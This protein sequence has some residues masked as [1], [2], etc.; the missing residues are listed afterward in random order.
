[1]LL[2]FGCLL[3]A[4]ICAIKVECPATRLILSSCYVSEPITLVDDSKLTIDV[5]DD[6]RSKITTFETAPNSNLTTI[7]NEIFET[8]AQLEVISLPL[9]NIWKLEKDALY[10]AT[11]LQILNLNGNNLTILGQ[12]VFRHA[13]ELFLLNLADNQINHIADGAFDRL[14]K[15]QTLKLNGN[16]LAVLSAGV[17]DGLPN[18][19]YL[20]LHDNQL[21]TIEPNMLAL[22]KLSEV[23]FTRNALSSLPEN[24]FAGTPNVAYVSFDYNSLKRI[25]NLFDG[26]D[27]LVFLSLDCNH[28]SDLS[29]SKFAAL[30]SLKVLSLNGTHIVLPTTTETLTTATKSPLMSL[31]LGN[32][33]L[34]NAD[35]MQH[36]TVFP[37][38]EHLYL[39]NN[40]F[41]S[42]RDPEKI[43]QLLPKLETLD[44]DG[45]ALIPAWL[46]ENKAIF[47]RD[48]IQVTNLNFD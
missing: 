27:K 36:L 15:L 44:L 20:H 11:K 42:I 26:C 16:K 17:L 43:K 24:L 21:H 41:N 39:Y 4:N 19:E 3:T 2:L 35:V 37:N 32:N 6:G 13:P 1:M 10:G 22:P 31:N 48:N 28:I 34:S 40:K 14:S 33:Q 25:G 29:L 12:N 38:L 7:P 5:D 46:T 45:N 30:K 8:F 23:Y 18:L 9:A 47:E